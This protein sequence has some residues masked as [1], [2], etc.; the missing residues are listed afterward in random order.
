MTEY[1]G[2][3]GFIG[4]G[5]IGKNYADDFEKRGYTAVRYSLDEPYVHNKEAIASCA[6]VFVA[7]PTPTSVG[8]QEFDG[9]I[10]RDALTSITTQGTIVVVKSTTI[11]GTIKQL[12]IEFPD[13][14]I[15]HSPEF[16]AEKTAAHD[17]ANPNRNIIGMPI[18][19]PEYRTHAETVMSI[20]PHAPYQII[21][22]SNETELIKYAGNMF[23]YFKVIFANLFY[24]ATQALGGD[25]EVVRQALGAD[26]RIGSSHLGV[27]D[28][29]GHAGAIPGRG[30]SGHCFMKDFAAMVS[31]YEKI[32]PEDVKGIAILRSIE[33]KNKDLL[34]STK[35][36][37]DL[38]ASVYGSL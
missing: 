9:S 31:L 26:P 19:T 33:E 24:D 12:Q 21:A 29:S 30:A 13:L 16:L 32:L 36:D 35:K 20:L 1:S 23:L 25:Y 34:I 2:K 22:D 28:A 4:Q 3:I 17:A 5:W 14:V 38:V 6:I 27:V 7:V 15:L 10:L 8:T 37:L 18:D 11:P